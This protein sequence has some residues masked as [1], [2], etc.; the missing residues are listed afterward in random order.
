M[1]ENNRLIRIINVRDIK[2]LGL[3]QLSGPRPG[4][5]SQTITREHLDE[6]AYALSRQSAGTKNATHYMFEELLH[7][8]VC[9]MIYYRKKE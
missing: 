5:T 7:Q 9:A 4:K 1:P 8:D 2:K 3:E 6:S